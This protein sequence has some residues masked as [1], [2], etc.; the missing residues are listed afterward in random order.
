MCPV[1]L[2][3]CDKL[4]SRLLKNSHTFF[5]IDDEPWTLVRI[6]PTIP[7]HLHSQAIRDKIEEIEQN[8]EQYWQ[9]TLEETMAQAFKKTKNTNGESSIPVQANEFDWDVPAITGTANQITHSPQN[10]IYA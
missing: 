6:P 2:V 9:F 10:D 5:L 3:K 7:K 8:R 4:N 1:F